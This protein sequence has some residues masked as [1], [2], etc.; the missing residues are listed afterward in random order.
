V[1]TSSKGRREKKTNRPL[2]KPQQEKKHPEKW[3]H[4]LSPN[5]MQGQNIGPSDINSG[6]ERRTAADI[7]VLTE[8]LGDLRMDELREIPIVPDGMQLKQGAVYLDLRNPSPVPFTASGG[9]TAGEHNYYVA[10]SEVSHEHWNR[11]LDVLSPG[12]AQGETNPFAQPVEHARSQARESVA[13]TGKGDKEEPVAESTVDETLEASFPASDP[14]AWTSGRETSKQEQSGETSNDDL[15][16]LS[17]EELHAEAGKL[18]IHGVD[19]MNREQLILAI[20]TQLS[21]TEV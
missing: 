8:R 11:L 20:R 4:D 17:D 6:V 12:G 13:V 2:G 18:K 14:P 3:E 21:G 9:M 7:K 1:V 5:R 15:N 10:K 16:N 19:S